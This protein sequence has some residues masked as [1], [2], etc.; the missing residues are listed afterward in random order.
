MGSKIK[1]DYVLGMVSRDDG[2]IMLVDSERLIDVE[3]LE[4]ADSVC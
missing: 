3:E 2:M 4:V 1:T